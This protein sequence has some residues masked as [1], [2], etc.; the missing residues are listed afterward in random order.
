[1][2]GN[3]RLLPLCLWI[4]LSL[5]STMA[6]AQ[7]TYNG[8]V[9]DEKGVPIQDVNVLL[10]RNQ[11]S[12][13]GYTFTEEDGRFQITAEKDVDPVAIGFVLQGYETKRIKIEEYRSGMDIKLQSVTFELREVNVR[14]ERIKQK[15]DTLVYNVSGFKLSQDRS[16]A[17]VINKMPGLAVRSDGQIT[18]EGKP[19]NKFY[20]EGLDLLGSKY[21]QASENISADMIKDVQVLQNHQPVRSLKGVRFSDQAALNIVLKDEMKNVWSG[22]LNAGIGSTAQ[23]LTQSRREFLYSA[24]M[25][26]MVFGRKMQ[27]L[28]MYKCDNTGKDITNEIQ[29]LATEL[30]GNQAEAGLLRRLVAPAA[31][32]DRE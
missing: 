10:Y 6:V 23:D 29:D 2:I 19:I 24:R 1:M 18:F 14:V 5:I 32:I 7:T 21:A 11:S 12:L 3:V 25:M 9:I 28:S 13:V 26:G 4:L 15:Q 22:I 31:A 8:R 16:I 17:D 30:R 20:I 27:N